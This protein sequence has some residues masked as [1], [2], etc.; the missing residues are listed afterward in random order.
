VRA[1]E[2]VDRD[3]RMDVWTRYDI[4]AGRERVVR[5]ERDTRGRGFADTFEI[6]EPRDDESVLV[7]REEDLNGDGEIDVVSFYAGGKLR[8][9]QIRDADV[10]SM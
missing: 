10:T 2:D 9:R 3:G 6:F 5:I 4:E 8:R 1:E 7:R